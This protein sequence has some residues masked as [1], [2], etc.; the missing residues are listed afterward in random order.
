MPVT[1]GEIIG[2]CQQ[3]CAPQC[4]P[5][6]SPPDKM[7]LIFDQE[8]GASSHVVVDDRPVVLR[9][10][11]NL[12]GAELRLEMIDGCGFGDEFAP[13]TFGCCPDSF[14]LSAS[15]F[16]LPITGRYRLVASDPLTVGPEDLMVTHRETKIA[17]DWAGI[18]LRQLTERC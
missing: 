15:M 2:G 9:T 16:V 3:G 17:M 12:S 1:T 18:M 6:P 4:T 14:C 10:M 5:D 13:V 11:R 7:L 8:T